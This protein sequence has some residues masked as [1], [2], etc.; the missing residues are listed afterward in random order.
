MQRSPRHVLDFDLF[1]FSSNSLA[2]LQRER[3][4]FQFDESSLNS[5]ET[6][7]HTITSSLRTMTEGSNTSNANGQGG[8]TGIYEDHPGLN[9]TDE[10]HLPIN[11]NTLYEQAS[12][13]PQDLGE[14]FYLICS[15]LYRL[16]Y[17]SPDRDLPPYWPMKEFILFILGDDEHIT[18]SYLVDVYSNLCECGIHSAY[19]KM[20]LDYL[21]LINGLS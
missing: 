9:P 8:S 17:L 21:D 19:W 16:F 15:E 10:T 11:L 18:P 4:I 2:E 20:A 13:D 12:P 3:L 5:T 1:S 6:S 7:V 14:D